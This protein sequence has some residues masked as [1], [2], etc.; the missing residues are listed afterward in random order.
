MTKITISAPVHEACMA[1]WIGETRNRLFDSEIE[2][3]LSLFADGKGNRSE[4]KHSSTCSMK[5]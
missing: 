3:Q 1:E 5:A 2:F 4:C